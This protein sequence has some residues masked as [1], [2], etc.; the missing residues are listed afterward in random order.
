MTDL[1]DE[2][3]EM[4]ERLTVAARRWQTEQP[5]PPGVPLD[6]LDERLPRPLGWRP[7]VAAAVAVLVVA[8]GAVALTR[9]Q[10]D[11]TPAPTTTTH[12]PTSAASSEPAGPLVAWKDLPAG[13]PDVRH[14][15]HG[16][17]VTPF[18]R[19]SATGRISGSVHPGDTLTF[20]AVLESS[21]DLTLDPCPDFNIAFG[22][23]SWQTWQLNCAGVPFRDDRGRPMLPAFQDV[24]FA[25]QVKVP[26]VRG[27]QKVL[28]T[29]DGPQSM[30]GFYGIVRVLRR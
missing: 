8:G 22:R 7:L 6:R 28:W 20:T 26:D 11:A 14:R 5:P 21:T 9:S 29:L 2:K 25:M 30:P 3:D 18:D 12:T 19:V 27:E 16:E 15:K 10:D 17:I 13:H 4:D 1:L 24:R 23:H